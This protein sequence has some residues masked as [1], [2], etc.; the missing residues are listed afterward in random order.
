MIDVNF[1]GA[2]NLVEAVV[3]VMKKQKLGKICF[4]SSGVGVSGYTNVCYYASSKG[5]IEALAKC[6]NIEYAGGGITF[7]IMHPPLTVTKS[8]SPFPVP[9]EFKASPEKVGKS[10]V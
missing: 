6:L 7:H 2:A 8:S 1:G 10:F 5:A 4:T 9:K 3:P